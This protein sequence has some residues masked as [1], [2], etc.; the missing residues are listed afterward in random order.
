LISDVVVSGVGQ[1]LAPVRQRL[2]QLGIV[3]DPKLAT[4]LTT[5]YP[6]WQEG[7]IL[8][9]DKK[10]PDPSMLQKAR[11]DIQEDRD[12]KKWLENET[13][14]KSFEAMLKD[15]SG[16]DYLF[17]VAAGQLDRATKSALLVKLA[18][19]N[20]CRFR[21]LLEDAL[22]DAMDERTRRNKLL[23]EVRRSLD[24][25][26][27]RHDRAAATP[28]KMQGPMDISAACSLAIRSLMYVDRDKLDPVPLHARQEGV[29][30]AD[31][32]QAQYHRWID[33]QGSI[34]HVDYVGLADPVLRKRFMRY[35]V[36]ATPIQEVGEW[37]RRYL[38]D[39]RQ[40]SDARAARSYVAMRMSNA[41]WQGPASNGGGW[42]HPDFD[43]I[44]G[45]SEILCLYEDGDI[46]ESGPRFKQSPHYLAIVAAF[47][48]VL[49][50]VLESHAG[51]RPP[52]SGDPELAQIKERFRQGL[53]TGP[54]A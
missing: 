5:N 31:F 32:V 38:G 33:T 10:P 51:T 14:Q 28:N 9:P 42:P 6:Q 18:E 15:S 11:K 17:E 21:A 4:L 24:D 37:V 12:F 27:N 53:A 44:K 30:F 45:V 8:G 3:S 26:L 20:M 49:D 2:E 22:P 29:I 50:R 1:G 39:V 34:P 41:L 36:E 35:L 46:P 48:G 54:Q 19:D 13:S 43:A 16:T 47:Q 40:D 7:M 25:A 23:E 52:Q